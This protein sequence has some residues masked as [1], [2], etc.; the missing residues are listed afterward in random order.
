MYNKKEL[1]VFFAESPV[2]RVFYGAFVFYC[3]K[4]NGIITAKR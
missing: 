1:E 4:R 3:R 2:K